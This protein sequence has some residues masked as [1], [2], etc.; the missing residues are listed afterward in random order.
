MKKITAALV[1]GF[2]SLN[3]GAGLSF[4]ASQADAVQAVSQP[5]IVAIDAG[6]GGADPGTQDQQQQEKTI[7]LQLALQLRQTLEKHQIKVV[8][9]RDQDQEMA[10]KDR[11][12][13]AIATGANCLISLHLE[14]PG[15]PLPARYQ[16]YYHHSEA[17]PLVSAIDQSLRRLLPVSTDVETQF[18]RNLYMIS[19]VPFPAVLVEA[20]WETFSQPQQQSELVQGLA[21]GVLALVR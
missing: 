16:L 3:V 1:L 17:M 10:L 14:A 18:Q 7:S 20:D 6:H 11:A 8:L 15:N 9:L 19:K 5:L 12:N 2:C 13:K 4:A 21:E